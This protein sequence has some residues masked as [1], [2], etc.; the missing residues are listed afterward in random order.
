MSWDVVLRYSHA[1]RCGCGLE[2]ESA[3]P[4]VDNDQLPEH[5][6]CQEVSGDSVPVGAIAE[7]NAP[8]VFLTCHINRGSGFTKINLY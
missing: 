1:S 3:S 5:A 2:P 4:E 8:G 6:A 7:T